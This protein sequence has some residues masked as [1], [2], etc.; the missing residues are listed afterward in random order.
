L[1]ASLASR[2]VAFV[3]AATMPVL[4]G[5]WAQAGTTLLQALTEDLPRAAVAELLRSP[6][7]KL[8]D[9]TARA[10]DVVPDSWDAWT[11]DARIVRGVPAF[12]QDVRAW[13]AADIESRAVR[14]DLPPS[15]IAALDWIVDRAR[16]IDALADVA[17]ALGREREAW[18]RCARPAQHAAFLRE[19]FGRWLEDPSR[20]SR[21]GH[22]LSARAAV[23][24]ALDE[25]ERL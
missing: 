24:A 1:E 18:A 20:T 10:E 21:P 23:G 14:D 6:W 17:R 15:E 3:T 11:L 12:T 19:L 9:K 16:R 5:P 13:H 8:G 2:G 4:R 25:L 22:A 7:A